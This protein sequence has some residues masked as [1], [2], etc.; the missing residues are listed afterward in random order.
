MSACHEFSGSLTVGAERVSKVEG[1]GASSSRRA[2]PHLE[3]AQIG[4]SRS[5]SP[6]KERIERRFLEAR[7]LGEDSWYL[8]RSRED[9][10]VK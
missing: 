5:V 3:I 8:S 10:K 4:A 6:A 7:K 1:G 9:G 2:E